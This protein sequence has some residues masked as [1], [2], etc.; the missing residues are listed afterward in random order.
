MTMYAP[1]DVKSIHL[2]DGCGDSHHRGDEP[3]LVVSCP[4]CETALGKHPKLG[5]AHNP[6]AVA[7]TPDERAQAARDDEKA[8]RAGVRRLA[9]WAAGGPETPT[10][11][12]AVSLVE[13]IARM[14]PQE[15]AALR[16]LLG[17]DQPPPPP[18]P[19]ATVEETPAPAVADTGQPEV[20]DPPA[21]APKRGP[22]RPRKS[23]DAPVAV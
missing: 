16:T 7:L 6:D 21:P 10:V 22:G 4:P 5:W 9:Q 23:V 18:A 11:G 17:T 2:P 1:S 13:Q 19:T 8:Q 14:T 15:K 3:G 20:A 12:P